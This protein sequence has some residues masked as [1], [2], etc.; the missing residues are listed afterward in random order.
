MSRVQEIRDS[1]TSASWR[2]CPGELNPADLPSRGMTASDLVKETTWWN[3]PEFLTKDESEWPR[4]NHGFIETEDAMKEIIKSPTPTTHVVTTIAQVGQTGIHH[5]I[6]ASHYSSF[7]K[8]L[9]VTAYVLRFTKG[10]VYPKGSELT[11]EELRYAEELWIKAIQYHTFPE[12]ICHLSATRNAS[13]PIL[14]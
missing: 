12:E 13:P 8:L 7:K 5:V 1:T 3:G 4:Q 10:S 6:D 14:V 11:A 9:R 2:H